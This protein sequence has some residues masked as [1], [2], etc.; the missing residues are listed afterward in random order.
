[1]S[2]INVGSIN[3]DYVHRVPH[4]PQ[5]GETLKNLDYSAGLG[6]K[7][8]NQSIAIALSGGEAKH[9]GR[10]GEDGLWAKDKLKS[11]GVNVEHI[12]TDEGASGHAVI[13]VDNSGEN[14]IVIH[15]GA[16]EKLDEKQLSAALADASNEDWLL[17]QNETNAIL[18][19][20][21][22]AKE[23]GLRVAYA[24][25]PFDADIAAEMIPHIDLLAVNEIEAQQ[26]ADTLDQPVTDLPVEK[27]LITK[28][29]KGAIYRDGGQQYAVDAFKVEPLDTTGAGDTFTGYFLARLDLGDSPE[30]ALKVASAAAAIQVTRLGA[31]DAIP[32][33]SEVFEFLENNK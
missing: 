4:F 6:G 19:A 20:A 25:A 15:G 27:I 7:G 1:M 23:K 28:G 17:I 29:S 18:E 33:I 21:K 5:A 9:V 31:A 26:L 12:V 2:I 3:I 10:V 22:M 30:T 14:T 32:P 24:A 11:K 16:N 8:G 13:Y